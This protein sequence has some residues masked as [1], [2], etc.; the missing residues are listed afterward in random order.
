MSKF[1]SLNTPRERIVGLAHALKAAT[2]GGSAQA[3]LDIKEAAISTSDFPALFNQ[4]NNFQV[5]A[6]Y[7]QPEE[8]VWQ[9]IARQ[10][11]LPDFRKHR[12]FEL[13]WD[14]AAMDAL[15][16]KN[17]GRRTVPGAL[18]NIPEGTEYPSA[19]KLYEGQEDIQTRKNGAQVP[20]TF[21]TIIN[22][23]WDVI[24]ELPTNL[25]RAAKKGEDAA[26]T[27][28]LAADDG[29]GLNT[30]NFNSTLGTLL[31]YG[32]NT[33]GTAALSRETL[34]A[35]LAQA[36]EFKAGPNKN[37]PVTFNKFAVVIPRALKRLSEDIMALPLQ[38]T[39]T[40]G[41]ETWV[42][43]FTYGENFEFVVNEQLDILNDTN[44]QT[45]WYVVPYAGEG[46]RPSLALAFLERFETPELRVN[47]E[48]GLMLGGGAVAPELGSFIND[49]WAMRIRHI[50]DG[51]AL[52][53]MF[54]CIA[55][56]GV[57]T[58]KLP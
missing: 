1:Y 8:Q 55:S 51:A 30:E 32:S 35:A 11:T 50:Y 47:N 54:G 42:E 20:V 16:A 52:N 28:Q 36:Q 13:G 3:R 4:V 33:E 19:F 9:K 17:G 26:I 53:D 15:L 38:I 45:A 39:K 29:S 57:E 21:E 44:G 46:Q 48:T 56:T 58:P 2:E 41:N 12:I 5:Q 24:R 23:Q 6:A 25:V 7:A 14:D 43:T 27:V 40:S 49:T 10:V 31:K 22:D 37:R 34:K 18:P